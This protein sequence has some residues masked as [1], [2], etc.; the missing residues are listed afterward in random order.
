MKEDLRNKGNS[1]KWIINPEESNT[2]KQD[3]AL[4]NKMRISKLLKKEENP[5]SL[6]EIMDESSFVE[7]EFK[8]PEIPKII[9][10]EEEL[11]GLNEKNLNDLLKL[12]EFMIGDWGQSSEKKKL[13]KVKNAY[14]P[15]KMKGN[16]TFFSKNNKKSNLEG[17]NINLE[18]INLKNLNIY[19]S[20]SKNNKYFNFKNNVKSTSEDFVDNKNINNFNTYNENQTKVHTNNLKLLSNSNVKKTNIFV[21]KKPEKSNINYQSN[22]IENNIYNISNEE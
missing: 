22:N 18:K 16:K 7:D 19:Q 17:K 5:V 3:N 15:Q 9:F 10:T 8:F 14:T 21:K 12:P 11:G 20:K 2:F 1:N 6:Y 4:E 13:K